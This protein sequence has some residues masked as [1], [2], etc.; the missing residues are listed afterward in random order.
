MSD[1]TNERLII[2]AL[3]QRDA[4]REKVHHYIFPD[5][6]SD[7]GEKAVVVTIQNFVA[8]YSTFPTETD[9]IVAL[10]NDSTITEDI[11]ED[12]VEVVKDVF[13]I[14]PSKNTEYLIDV[15]RE[16]CKDK[17]IYNAIQ[18]TIEVYKGEAKASIGIP[19]ML[20]NALSVDFD[21]T[22]G[23]DYFEQAAARYDYYQSPVTKIPFDIEIW[24]KVTNGGVERKTL[25]AL[26][27]GI[28]VGKTMTLVSLA[29]MYVRMG[30]NVFYASKEMSDMKIS[31]RVDA[32]I[33]NVPI[34]SVR[35]IQREVFMTK[36]GKMK[37]KGYGRLF[38]KD[39]AT[40]TGHAGL[41]QK[42]I[43]DIQTK[44]KVKID[45]MIVDYV[46]IVTPMTPAMRAEKSYAKYKAVT[47]ELRAV[48]VTEDLIGWTALQFNRGGLD[49]SDPGMG[50]VGECLSPDTIVDV[51]GRGA[52]AIRDLRVGD[53]INGSGKPVIVKMTHCPKVKAAYRI[54]TKSG[55]EIIAS[56]DHVF[57][58]DRGRLSVSEMVIGE[59]L[60]TLNRDT[61]NSTH[62]TCDSWKEGLS[63]E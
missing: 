10:K 11:T 24:N 35:D 2:S 7:A 27:A 63:Q 5:Y 31:N 39:Y 17:A 32:N 30:L 33:L 22:I 16:F 51:Q 48:C 47:E 25:N 28:N 40:G 34:N 3:L 41:F 56:G 15:A 18:K 58:T 53:V 29:A 43:R 8:K 12:A 46:Q 20:Q 52:V 37:A 50:D 49:N 60:K 9:L 57:P 54:R 44:Q 26:A 61:G 13:D 62:T 38:V 55:R 19:E 14:Q 42:D 45:V 36:I 6:F 1:I 4:F 59:K 21:E 23:H